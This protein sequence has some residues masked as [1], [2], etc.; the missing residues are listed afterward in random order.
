MQKLTD[1]GVSHTQKIDMFITKIIQP[2]GISLCFPG[3]VLAPRLG[4]E[5]PAAAARSAALRDGQSGEGGDAN[6]TPGS[7]DEVHRS[8]TG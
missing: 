5:P 3:P 6:A 7:G 1:M 4:P 2:L 8:V